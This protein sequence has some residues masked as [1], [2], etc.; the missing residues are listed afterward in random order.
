MG[1]AGLLRHPED[2]L[3]NIFVSVLGGLPAPFGQNR[4]MALLEGIG[5]IF[6]KDKS[7]YDVL[8]LGG[9]HRSAQGV[10]HVPELGFVAGRGTR[11]LRAHFRGSARLLRLS[12]SFVCLPW[13]VLP[14]HV[15]FVFECIQEIYPELIK[16]AHIAGH[17]RQ[18]VQDGRRG[19]HGVLHQSV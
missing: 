11:A 19:D 15:G 3:G 14:P 6:Q 13:V 8:V 16:I 4:R 1:P 18:P 2:I 12:A 17:G 9:I 5:D 10:G 7:E